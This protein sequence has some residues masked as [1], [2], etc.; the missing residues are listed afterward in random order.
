MRKN[1]R[2]T[3]HA[4]PGWWF[5]GA[6]LVALALGVE[7]WFNGA[8]AVGDIADM[9]H[10]AVRRCCVGVDHGLRNVHLV[11]TPGTRIAHRSKDDGIIGDRPRFR[12]EK[13]GGRRAG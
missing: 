7:A 13:G 1:Y 4:G 9:G 10:E 6:V 11:A 12:L 8:P 2:H 3:Q 5:S